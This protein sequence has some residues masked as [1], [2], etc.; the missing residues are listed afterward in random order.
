M[1]KKVLTS[2]GQSIVASDVASAIQTANVTDLIWW[3]RWWRWSHRCRCVSTS[4]GAF[5]SSTVS[6]NST[7]TGAPPDFDVS[8]ISP[9][10]SPGVL[11]NP[12][13]SSIL[14]SPTYNSNSMIDRFGTAA[15]E[16]SFVG[17]RK[18]WITGIDS[19]GNCS[20]FIDKL[21]QFIFIASVVNN[22]SGD[23]CSGIPFGFV[24]TI[25]VGVSVQV[26]VLG[27]MGYSAS[28]ISQILLVSSNCCSIASIC[29][30]EIIIKLAFFESLG[31]NFISLYII[32]LL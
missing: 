8:T 13:W 24:G 2:S 28:S 11:N 10:R 12:V 23:F 7:F 25:E 1:I 5:S 18:S 27:F 15:R 26:G 4:V 6:S 9:A 16:D 30:K 32:V 3:N 22:S 14:S 29:P 31:W 20:I 21:F 17:V 19:S